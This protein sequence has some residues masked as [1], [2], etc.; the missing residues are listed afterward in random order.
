MD[1]ITLFGGGYFIEKC[2]GRE[3]LLRVLGPTADL[4]GE[5]LAKTAKNIFVNAE[6]KISFHRIPNDNRI[7]P[8][9]VHQL[10][11]DWIYNDEEI[12]AEYYGGVLAASKSGQDDIGTTIG[13][14]IT[15]LSSYSLR[16]HYII[17][18]ALR[19]RFYG[20]NIN[21]SDEAAC[22]LCRIFINKNDMDKAMGFSTADEEY[23]SEI[24]SSCLNSL[25]REGLLSGQYTYGKNV[26]INSNF[27]MPEK[28]LVV[29]PTS[30][31]ASL[32][33]WAAGYGLQPGRKLF[34]PNI[35]L[36]PKNLLLL[37]QIDIPPAIKIGRGMS[38]N[39]GGISSLAHMQQM[40]EY[41]M[42]D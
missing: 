20:K 6:R 25:A 22:N 2:G 42:G 32:L 16:F 23:I 3:L 21:L 18:N 5:K 33:L 34:Y 36:S 14:M 7:N 39:G 30:V 37:D 15:R 28:G 19:N 17:Y 29:G 12:F 4:I 9:I 40:E 41:I 24:Y 13:Q 26:H 35:T 27:T 11:H 8:S 1:L 38:T 31:G 10:T